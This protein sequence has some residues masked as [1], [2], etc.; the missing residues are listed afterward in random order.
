VLDEAQ[1]VPELARAIKLAVDAD[2]RPGRFLLT[3]SAS[4][5]MVPQLSESLAGRMEILTLWPLSQGEVA[6]VRETFIDQMFGKAMPLPTVQG[7]PW[8][9]LVKRIARG[10]YPELLR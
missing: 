7:E 2:R 4:V 8:S 6:G 5:L 3:G 10:G 1:R 9:G